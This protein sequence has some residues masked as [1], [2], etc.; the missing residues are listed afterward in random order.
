MM[1]ERTTPKSTARATRPRDLVASEAPKRVTPSDRGHGAK[2]RPFAGRLDEIA[3]A[4]KAGAD[5]ESFQ[6][7]LD[8]L[9][10]TELQ[11]RDGFAEAVFQGRL[12]GDD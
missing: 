8:K 4:I 2:Q 6:K 9:L 11:P 7:E 3:A 1:R 5:P 12:D 10:D